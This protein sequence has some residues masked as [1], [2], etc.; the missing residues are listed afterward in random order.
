MLARWAADDFPERML[1]AGVLQRVGAYSQ[2]VGP[3][4]PVSNRIPGEDLLE[5][6][7]SSCHKLSVGSHKK[8]LKMPDNAS[9][10]SI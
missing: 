1:R 6:T 2:A 8:D 4:V 5:L 7:L 9:A 10:K 3:A